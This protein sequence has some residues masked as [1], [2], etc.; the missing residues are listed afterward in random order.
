MCETDA[1]AS[2]SA[3][4]CFHEWPLVVFTALAIP[5]AGILLV[6]P[7]FAVLESGRPETDAAAPWF[8]MAMLAVGLGASLVHLGRP[9]LAP[10]ALART[11]RNALGTEVALASLAL[12]LAVVCLIPGIPVFARVTCARSAGVSSLLF[13]IVLG[14]VY[15]FPARWPW[16]GPIAAGPLV[17]GLAAG[18]VVL[19]AARTLALA[20]LLLDLSLSVLAWSRMPGR[21]PLLPVHPRLFAHRR[22]LLPLRWL[23]VN[24]I[25]AT[26]LLATRPTT[27]VVV[28]LAGIVL[29]RFAFYALAMQQ[30]TEAQ[31]AHVERAIAEMDCSS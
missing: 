31:V 18:L 6:V 16:H 7:L 27:A 11:G 24:A 25:P 13:L 19:D 22:T 23:T 15:R 2:A 9:W 17:S 1:G 30:S 10:L 5:A 14:A 28:F 29:D 21:R 26:L 3:G 4:H 20:F 12:A 8:A